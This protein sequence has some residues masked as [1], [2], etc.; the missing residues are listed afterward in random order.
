MNA[1]HHMAPQP[2]LDRVKNPVLN[3]AIK[4]LRRVVSHGP[5]DRIV[6]AVVESSKGEI[7]GYWVSEHELSPE[8]IAK[9][10]KHPPK[11]RKE[12]RP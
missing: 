3:A 12:T 1:L 2:V 7:L 6:L 11:A 4:E 10:M 8:A 9:L 5:A